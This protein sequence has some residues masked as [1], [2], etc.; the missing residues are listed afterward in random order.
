M[1][2]KKSLVVSSLV[3]V[4]TFV[5]SFNVNTYDAKAD[6]A[7]KDPQ[8]GVV[9]KSAE[10]NTGKVIVVPKKQEARNSTGVNVPTLNRGGSGRTDVISYA[11]NFI[12]IPYVWGANGPGAFDCS[13]F[14]AYVYRKFGISLPHYTGSQFAMGSSVS[15]SSLAAGDL[16]FFNTVGPI[17]HVGIY[18]GAGK[19][20]HAS[21]GSHRVTVS[22][23]NESYYSSK[24]AGARRILN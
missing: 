16:V 15:K 12:G 23:L 19:F 21:S 4:L 10:V 17:A 9:V 2:N 6:A 20:V 7:L 24:Y 22:S 8:L 13:G 14:T 11:Y 1:L 3:M 5:G 18:I